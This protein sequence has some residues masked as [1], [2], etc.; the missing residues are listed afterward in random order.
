MLKADGDS[1]LPEGFTIWH[2]V[3]V[4]FYNLNILNSS[5][6]VSQEFWTMGCGPASR[7]VLRVVSRKVTQTVSTG[8]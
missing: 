4:L 5:A 8:T 6:C 3:V 2:M 1:G 7:L